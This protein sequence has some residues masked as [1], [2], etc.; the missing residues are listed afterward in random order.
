[1]PALDGPSDGFDLPPILGS[2][3]MM[4]E[5]SWN[6][7]EGVGVVCLKGVPKQECDKYVTSVIQ[8]PVIG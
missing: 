7:K 6:L 2:P 8:R 3:A 4:Y 5:K 1:M